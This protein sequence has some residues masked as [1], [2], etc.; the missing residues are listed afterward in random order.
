MLKLN[1]EELGEERRLK[2]TTQ[3]AKVSEGRKV[4]IIYARR[5]Y[6]FLFI[7]LL[8]LAFVCFYGGNYDDMKFNLLFCKLLNMNQAIIYSANSER[9]FKE[10]FNLNFFKKLLAQ[11]NPHITQQMSQK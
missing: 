7:L 10:N 5:E 8:P 4:K 6:D 9:I 11:K 1:P 3:T 2:I